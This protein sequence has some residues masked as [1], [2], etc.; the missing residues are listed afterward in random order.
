M[1][2]HTLGPELWLE[3]W[4]KWKIR[5]KHCLTW[6]MARN[7]ENMKRE[8]YTLYDLDHGE[9]TE[10]HGKWDTQTIGP[11]LWWENSKTWKMSQKHCRT[12]NMFEN[13]QTRKKL[14]SH[15][16]TCNIAKNTEK[17]AKWETNTIGLGIWWENWK[18]WKMRH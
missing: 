11:G 18:T 15:V 1:K 9:K 17:H 6:N 2:I 10:K 13:W 8:K 4:K 14:N 3:N 12:W 5:H 16:N 7:S